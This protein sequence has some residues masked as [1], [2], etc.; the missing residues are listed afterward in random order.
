[1]MQ[2][3]KAR[4]LRIGD[5]I[6]TEHAKRT[7]E[8]IAVGSESMWYR[9]DVEDEPHYQHHGLDVEVLV[10]QRAPDRGAGTGRP[11]STTRSSWSAELQP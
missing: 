6:A 9:Y 4:E 11:E 8:D 10:V 2:P 7:V 1:M 3:I 5:V